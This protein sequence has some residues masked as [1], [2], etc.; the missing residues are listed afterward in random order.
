MKHLKVIKRISNGEGD[1]KDKTLIE[2]LDEETF[3]L[4]LDKLKSEIYLEETENL[5]KIS[6]IEESCTKVKKSNKV[7]VKNTPAKVYVSKRIKAIKTVKR[8]KSE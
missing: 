7:K 8:N 2:S 3:N 4:L 5:P 6:F 1:L